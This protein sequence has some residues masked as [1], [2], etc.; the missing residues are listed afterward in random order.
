MLEIQNV[1]VLRKKDLNVIKKRSV[2]NQILLFDTQRRFD[3]YILKLLYRKNG[4]YEDI[5]HFVI[6]KTGIIYKI[7]N[8]AYSSNT[9]NNPKIDKKQIK[10]AIENLGWLNK[11]TIT[12]ILNNWINDPYRSEPYIK[13][14][15][16]HYYWD[17]YTKEQL[18]SVVSL[19]RMLC[20]KH[21]IS[22]NIISSQDNLYD[23]T[24]FKGILCKSNFQTIYTDINPSFDFKIFYEDET[25]N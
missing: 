9:F 7:F 15:R 18:I 5:P 3:E 1:S 8:T 6:S 16:N 12:G 23:S 19:C 4:R 25:E 17:A 13:N 24:N 20:S 11:N 2:K 22:Y 10:I 21:N 14:W